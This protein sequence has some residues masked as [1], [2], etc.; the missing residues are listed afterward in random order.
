[1]SIHSA[2][3]G[4]DSTSIGLDIQSR[5][6][7]PP[8]PPSFIEVGGDFNSPGDAGRWDRY[9]ER[10]GED[11]VS[12]TSPRDAERWHRY[13]ETRVTI[14]TGGP[15]SVDAADSNGARYEDWYR[16]E[17]GRGERRY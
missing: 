3:S 9:Q 11:H 17:T 7:F 12:Y 5:T 8:P 14:D 6:S 10:T 13:Q 2:D 15:A 16:E 4:Y 1:M